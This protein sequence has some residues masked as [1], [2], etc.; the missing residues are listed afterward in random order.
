M[1]TA[2]DQAGIPS[3]LT[4]SFAGAYHGI[5][6][7]TQD[8]DLIVDPTPDQLVALVRALPPGEYY[9]DETA[10]LEALEHRSQFNVVD[11]DSGWK[12]DLICRKAR[13]FSETEFARRIPVLF[14]AIPV[15]VVTIEDLILAKLEWAAMGESRRQLEDVAALLRVR[16]SDLDRSYLTHWIGQ[17]GLES[18]W[19]L[20]AAAGGI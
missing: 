14:N 4:G 3:M 9:V 16:G 17:L 7:A 5:P 6:R 8:I 11:M 12:I 2:L 1:L 10:A 13:P 18:Q 19:R 15:N 20:A